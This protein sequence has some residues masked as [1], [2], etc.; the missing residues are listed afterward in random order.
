MGTGLTTQTIDYSRRIC[1][2]L[3]AVYEIHQNQSKFAVR[4]AFGRSSPLRFDVREQK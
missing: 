2:G 4:A 1:Q 3:V